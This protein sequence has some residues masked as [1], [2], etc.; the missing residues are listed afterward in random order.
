M[1]RVG[2]V[3]QEKMPVAQKKSIKYRDA[4]L[5]RL[6]DD[7]SSLFQA[8]ARPSGQGLRRMGRGNDRNARNPKALLEHI[9]ERNCGDE[10]SVP[11]TR[12]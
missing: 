10:S 7:R 12:S 4:I 8:S 3:F 11:E 1:I 9:Q 6:I 2:V 5:L